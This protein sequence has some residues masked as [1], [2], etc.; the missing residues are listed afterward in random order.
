M[1]L[2][3][4]TIG[5]IIYNCVFFKEI[6]GPLYLIHMTFLERC[7]RS[8]FLI[9]ESVFQIHGISFLL[10]LVVAKTVYSLS[11]NI[12]NKNMLL[13]TRDSLDWINQTFLH[14]FHFSLGFHFSASK[15]FITDLC[16]S[17][18]HSVWFTTILNYQKTFLWN[19]NNFCNEP[20]PNNSEFVLTERN[21]EKKN[22]LLFSKI[23]LLFIE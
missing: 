9:G 22:I 3:A 5:T 23:F 13:R 21:F 20:I 19:W 11:I 16:S 15:N 12:F 14:K 18:L 7:A 2:K 8:V 6:K 17:P 4:L 1:L 10:M